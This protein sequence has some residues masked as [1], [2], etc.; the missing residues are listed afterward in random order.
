M[1]ADQHLALPYVV[2]AVDQRH[3]AGLARAGRSDQRH[4]L[5]GVHAEADILEHRLVAPVAE[6]DIA[7]LDRAV[8]VGR[9]R[10]GVVLVLH[11]DSDVEHLGD[12]VA[13]GHGPLH[14]AVLHGERADRVE[15]A[16]D[17]EEEGDHHAD[18]ERVPGDQPAADGDDDRHGRAGQRVDDRN[19]DLGVAAPRAGG[20]AGWRAPSRRKVEVDRAGGSCSARCAR[21][22]CPRP[23]RHWP[24]NWSHAP[25]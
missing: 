4:R 1:A 13:G 22:G 21:R 12:A 19:H 6:G 8:H 23:A 18:I 2:E 5:A 16:L 20:P 15:E 17:V 24:P 3:G 9:Q 7:E 11:V 25:P 14:D 10:H